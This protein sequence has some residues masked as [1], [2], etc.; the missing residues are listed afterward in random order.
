MY[1][2]ITLLLV[3]VNEDASTDALFTGSQHKLIHLPCAA[4]LPVYECIPY[5]GVAENIILA[6]VSVTCEEVLCFNECLLCTIIGDTLI[7]L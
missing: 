2:N 7:L 1:S 6:M 3:V 5:L 4:R